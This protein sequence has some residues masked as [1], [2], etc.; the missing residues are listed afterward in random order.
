MS[1]IKDPGE[2]VVID[3]DFSSELSAVDSAVV[4][5]SV[6]AGADATP[7]AV[8]DGPMQILGKRV[9]Q[10]VSGGVSGTSYKLRAV[11][12]RGSDVIVRTDILEVKTA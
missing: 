1:K 2:S 8:L 11:A 12:T 5:I 9:L 3:F 10:R 7:A 6:Y 4:G